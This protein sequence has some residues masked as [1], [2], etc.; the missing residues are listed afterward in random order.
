MKLNDLSP[1]EFSCY[2]HILS[3]NSFIRLLTADRV[4]LR[5][6]LYGMVEEFTLIVIWLTGFRAS[7]TSWKLVSK[8]KIIQPQF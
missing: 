8:L 7:L 1:V 6:G 5:T 4:V 3:V 2:L